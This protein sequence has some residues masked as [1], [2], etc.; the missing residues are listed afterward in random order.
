MNP[1][2]MLSCVPPVLPLLCGAALIGLLTPPVAAAKPPKKTAVPLVA[3]V[4]PVTPLAV[5]APAVA[6]VSV[7]PNA[8]PLQHLTLP[9]LLGWQM[10]Y[11]LNQDMWT[12]T[13]AELTPRRG[14]YATG[15]LYIQPLGDQ[16]PTQA[17]AF[18]RM[19]TESGALESGVR[20]VEVERTDNADQGFVIY[21]Q[22]KNDINPSAKPYPSF[23]MVRHLAGMNVLCRQGD[24]TDLADPAELV[25]IGV[26]LCLQLTLAK[27][28]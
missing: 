8:R 10:S 3:P 17:E 21:G 28:H 23:V 24:A 9:E 19:I 5:I 2:N 22:E 26:N 16:L 12:L 14:G 20:F 27:N 13:N 7:A 4:V 11:N 25:K 1:K 6:S 18:A 15:T